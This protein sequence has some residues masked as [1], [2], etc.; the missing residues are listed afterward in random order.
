MKLFENTEDLNIELS[1]VE[2]V[3]TVEL[4]YPRLEHNIDDEI[5]DMDWKEVAFIESWGREKQ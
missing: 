4:W 2:N 5:C 3:A 1:A